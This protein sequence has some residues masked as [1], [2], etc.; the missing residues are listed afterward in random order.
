MF[1]K[2]ESKEKPK[3]YWESRPH[4]VSR[5]DCTKILEQ[6]EAR[7]LPWWKRGQQLTKELTRQ[8]PM[9]YI[10]VPYRGHKCCLMA[11]DTLIP[12]YLGF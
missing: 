8:E 2:A 3:G 11:R 6:D 4:L 1:Q 7:G 9:N 5:L 12:P 10:P